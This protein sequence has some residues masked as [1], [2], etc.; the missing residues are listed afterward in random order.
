MTKWRADLES[1]P[2]LRLLREL[3]DMIHELLVMRN[4]TTGLLCLFWLTFE[5]PSP[6]IQTSLERRM[7]DAG[8]CNPGNMTMRRPS[9]SAESSIL[10][11]VMK[12]IAEGCSILTIGVISRLSI[13]S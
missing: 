9:A 7:D 6:K 13:N 2:I 12:Q 5:H 1:I 8:A 3:R 10:D 4:K 11:K